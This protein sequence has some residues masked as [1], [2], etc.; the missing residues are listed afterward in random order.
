MTLGRWEGRLAWPALEGGPGAGVP[1]VCRGAAPSPATPF[2]W[3]LAPSSSCA[4]LLASSNLAPGGGPVCPPFAFSVRPLAPVPPAARVSSFLLKYLTRFPSS[5]PR[6]GRHGT[7]SCAT[8]VTAHGQAGTR[9][10]AKPPAP[11][12][13]G[14]ADRSPGCT[15]PPPCLR[16]Q[17]GPLPAPLPS[18][19]EGKLQPPVRAGQPLPA[20]RGGPDTC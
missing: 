20:T 9:G 18:G 2:L 6:L 16:R 19:M 3:G 13:R 15:A 7:G 11:E 12:H 5:G 1:W 14:R 17:P 10:T 8:A 4:K